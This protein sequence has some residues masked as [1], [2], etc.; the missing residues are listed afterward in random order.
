MKATSCP[1]LNHRHSNAPVRY[2]PSCGEVVNDRVRNK[3][4][5]RQEHAR[6]RRDG[7]AF[8]IDCGERLRAEVRAPR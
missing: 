4:S 2:C 8:C 3:V 1:N 5:C 7:Y 6:R